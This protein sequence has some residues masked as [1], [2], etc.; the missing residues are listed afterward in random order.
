MNRYGR[1]VAIGIREAGGAEFRLTIYGHAGRELPPAVL[2]ATLT[3][4]RA[5]IGQMRGSGDTAGAPGGTPRQ[6]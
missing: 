1:L 3:E 6:S 4:F 2:I 5:W